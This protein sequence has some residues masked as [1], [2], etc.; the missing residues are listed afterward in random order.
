MFKILR[1]NKSPKHGNEEDSRMTTVVKIIR[2]LGGTFLIEHIC[3]VYLFLEKI[4]KM[5]DCFVH[6]DLIWRLRQIISLARQ[7]HPATALA[8]KAYDILLKA[9][10][11]ASTVYM[12]A[13]G[14][15][16]NNV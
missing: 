6:S 9:S 16:N 3:T 15:E 10:F 4:H 2:L 12:G 13:W 8:R 7:R 11:V 5:H 1:L 14:L